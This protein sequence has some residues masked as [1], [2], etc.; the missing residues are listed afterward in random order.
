MK[1]NIENK[2][3]NKFLYL[4]PFVLLAGVTYYYYNTKKENSSENSYLSSKR[5]L[6]SIPEQQET[7]REIEI[8]FEKDD[9]YCITRYSISESLP[10]Y[11]EREY[12]EEDRKEFIVLRP[13]EA[14]YDYMDFYDLVSKNKDFLG[15][16]E[17]IVHNYGITPL[18]TR[19]ILR[20]LCHNMK[21]NSGVIHVGIWHRKGNTSNEQLLGMLTISSEEGNEEEVKKGKPAG[22]Y[23]SYW[24]GDPKQT[25][26]SGVVTISLRALV[27][28]MIY[29]GRLNRLN[30]V[31]SEKNK[32]SLRV[33]EKLG[34]SCFHVKD[35]IPA[36]LWV[37]Y[38]VERETSFLFTISAKK[39]K[40]KH[41]D[42]DYKQSK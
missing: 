17:T 8:P 9:L 3:F 16:E 26:V 40:K 13:I 1:R 4:V 18:R 15:Y 19:T 7:G 37:Y 25:G 22:S 30:L 32:G 33:A 28:H 36:D 42:F 20:N 11:I 34:L 21:K 12:P 24:I 35:K 5:E 23:A 38:N 27:D 2:K 41:W 31:I 29:L 14:D 39:W 10:I 6:E